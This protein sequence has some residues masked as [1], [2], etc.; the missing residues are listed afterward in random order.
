MAAPKRRLSS[1]DKSLYGLAFLK[2]LM[3]PGNRVAA[4]MVYKSISNK[5]GTQK[6]FPQREPLSAQLLCIEL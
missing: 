5:L 2:Y 3:H 1:K 6:F 4:A